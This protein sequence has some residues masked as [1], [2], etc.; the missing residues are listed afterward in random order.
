MA[1]F[2]P[3]LFFEA[4][5]PEY[6]ENEFISS[7]ET[8][9]SAGSAQ[10]DALTRASNFI[11]RSIKP[12]AHLYVQPDQINEANML[13]LQTAQAVYT[14][15]SAMEKFKTAVKDTTHNT[16]VEVAVLDCLRPL[17]A[18]AHVRTLVRALIAPVKT[19]LG[20]DFAYLIVFYRNMLSDLDRHYQFHK[21]DK[22]YKTQRG[23]LAVAL[24]V[25]V[26]HELLPQ[27]TS[28][29]MLES[30]LQRRHAPRFTL[31][32]TEY[33]AEIKKVAGGEVRTECLVIIEYLRNF[34]TSNDASSVRWA[35]HKFSTVLDDYYNH[36]FSLP[37]RKRSRPDDAVLSSMLVLAL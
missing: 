1:E 5:H 3:F 2:E 19:P 4:E 25:C 26:L 6:L 13:I 23:T 33:L 17:F 14:K 36:F 8:S 7:V 15:T 30:V 32:W 12:A 29:S 37:T 31:E 18:T 21:K 28:L 24:L 10:S 27:A 20:A 22:V 11:P 16:A 34:V 9:S 35:M